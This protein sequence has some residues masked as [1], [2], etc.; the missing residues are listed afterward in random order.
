MTTAQIQRQLSLIPLRVLVS[1]AH[2]LGIQ[3]LDL[4]ATADKAA[5]IDALETR[6]NNGQ[7]TID[8]I[9]GTTGAAL[10]A[11]AAPAPAGDAATLALAKRILGESQALNVSTVE[12]R[13]QQQREID[14][15]IGAAVSQCQDAATTA[16]QSAADSIQK[17][18]RQVSKL[19]PPEVDAV[20]IQR[21]IDTAVGVAFGAFRKD[22][23]V[24]AVEAVAASLPPVTRTVRADSVFPADACSY[25]RTKFGALQVQVWDDAAAPAVVGDY[26][27]QP[28][29]LHQAL[30]ALDSTLPHNCWLAGERGTGKTEFVT[31]IAARLQRR[32]VRVNFD[33]AL[34]RADF[35]GGNTIEQGTV[36]WKGGIIT[37]AIQHPGTIVLLDEVGFAR[38]TAVAVL[39]SLCERSPNRSLTVSETGQR[40]PVSSGVTFFCADN[41]N[42]HGNTSGNFGGV[43]E[44]NSAFIDRFSYTLRFDYLDAQSEATLIS[45]RTGLAPAAAQ[46]IVGFATVARQKAAAGLLTQP[47]S[48]R[49]LF[50]LADAV[51][52]GLPLDVAFENAVVN[53]FHSDCAPELLGCF[54][55]TFDE[56]S[57]KQA[58]E[59]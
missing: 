9:K 43:L 46:I 35:I 6:I 25:G 42:G 41:S 31:Q 55:A 50:A 14:A 47:P 16:A 56:A 29:H 34:E 49:Q 10:A 3:E 57:F 1:A 12:A 5:L 52:K 51:S 7:I 21:S 54:A 38:P 27:F 58:L 20:A 19:A 2:S 11:P 8:Q 28:K 17:L 33:E 30:L 45:R 53:K 32:L 22:A 59:G 36:V 37:Q 39:H 18:E 13:Q 23:T 15:R 26:V 44:Q 24:E 4:G 40:I 48:L